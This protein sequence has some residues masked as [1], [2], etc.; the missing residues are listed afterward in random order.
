[1]Q[2]YRNP[3]CLIWKKGRHPRKPCILIWAEVINH[4]SNLSQSTWPSIGHST[5]ERK[6]GLKGV[7][8]WKNDSLHLSQVLLSK[9][10]TIQ[11]SWHKGRAQLTWSPSCRW[12]GHTGSAPKASHALAFWVLTFLL[13]SEF[14]SSAAFWYLQRR[15]EKKENVFKLNLYFYY[16]NL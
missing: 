9:W 8:L 2:W 12:L 1:M 15:G 3:G 5:Q 6:S 7:H 14:A 4:F 16:F 13:F 10:L 11:T